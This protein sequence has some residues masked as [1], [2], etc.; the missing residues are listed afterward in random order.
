MEK[1]PTHSVSKPNK[2]LPTPIDQLRIDMSGDYMKKVVNYYGGREEEAMRFMTAAVDYVRRLPKLLECDK[3]SLLTA[4]VTSAQ[5]RFM[6]SG[7]SGEA[8]IIPYG[9]EAKFQLGYQ[10][11][12]TLLYRTGKISTITANIIYKNDEFDYQEGLEAHLVHKPAMFGKARGEAIGVYTVIKMSDGSKTFKVMDKAAVMEIKEISKAKTSKDSPWNSDK[13]PFLWMW[14]KTCLLQHAKLLP[15]TQE[16]Q[17]AIETDYEG[18]G[19][20]KPRLDAFG[21]ATGR[22]LHTNDNSVIEQV[23]TQTTPEEKNEKLG[24]DTSDIKL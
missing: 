17:K 5:F 11:V 12:V 1:T 22:A 4:F 20:D 13:D 6:P 18:E 14:A 7:V 10:G 23:P 15:K 16:I 21:P 3:Q 9:R 2:Q 8:Y 19:I 24:I